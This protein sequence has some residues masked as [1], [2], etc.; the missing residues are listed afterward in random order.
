MIIYLYESKCLFYVGLLKFVC[1]GPLNP[2]A[3]VDSAFSDDTYLY[4]FFMPF[5]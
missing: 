2:A 1:G 3:S 5:F 4:V